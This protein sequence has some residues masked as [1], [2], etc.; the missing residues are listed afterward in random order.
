[1]RPR[2]DGNAVDPRREVFAEDGIV[3]RRRSQLA[4]CPLEVR[5]NG[6]PAAKL[7]TE[8]YD[9]ELVGNGF[10]VGKLFS[11]FSNFVEL[12]TTPSLRVIA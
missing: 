8:D 3:R 4:P 2:I 11:A 10:C 9:R 7:A 5:N 12:D 1:M 6:L